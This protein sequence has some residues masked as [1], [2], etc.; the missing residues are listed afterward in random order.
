MNIKANSGK[1]KL[2]GAVGLAAAGI[3]ASLVLAD[4]PGARASDSKVQDRSQSA[5]A[6]VYRGPRT[7]DAAEGWFEPRTVYTGPKT[8]DAAAAWR[9]SE[10]AEYN[11]PKTADAA[12]RWLGARR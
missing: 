10:A 9:E 5:P 4:D 12:E 11:G 7:A 6:H 1:K 8:A 2:A 3:A